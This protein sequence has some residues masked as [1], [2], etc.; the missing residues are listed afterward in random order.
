MSEKTPEEKLACMSNMGIDY[1]NTCTLS[2]KRS[3]VESLTLLKIRAAIKAER[4]RCLKDPEALVDCPDCYSKVGTGCVA[5]DGLGGFLR[6]SHD[7]R[8]EA[9]IRAEP[10]KEG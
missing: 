9:A 4:E 7:A 1:F 2:E 5:T 10:G 8:W 3:Y 6:A